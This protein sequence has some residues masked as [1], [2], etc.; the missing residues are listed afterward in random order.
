MPGVPARYLDERGCRFPEDYGPPVHREQLYDMEGAWDDRANR[1]TKAI[2]EREAVKGQ[3]YSCEA[4]YLDPGWDTQFATFIWGEKWLGPRKQFIR[5]M[6]ERYGL[7]VALHCPLATWATSPG[8]AMG[9]CAPFL[10]E[11]RAPKTSERRER[12]SVS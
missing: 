7:E 4:L 12:T 6:K 9:P 2:V 5:E 1:Y 11:G 10:A 3:D 8:M